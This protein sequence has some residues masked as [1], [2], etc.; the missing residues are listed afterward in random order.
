MNNARTSWFALFAPGILV[1]ATGVGAGDLMTAS[2][3]GSK[4]G[5]AILWAAAAGCL[6]KWTLNEGIA[7][8]QMATET[9]LLEGWVTRLGRWIQWVF[10][11][12]FLL[13]TFFVGGALINA[14]GVAGSNLL[15]LGDLNTSRIIWGTAHAVAGLGLVWAGGF[16]VFEKIMATFIALKFLAVIVTALLLVQDWGAVLQGLLVPRIPPGGLPWTLG[17]LG[18][19]GGT[20]TLLSYGYWIREKQ[21]SGVEGVRIC[22]VDLGVAYALTAMF[23]LAMIIIGSRIQIES[24]GARMAS[25]LA[26]QLALVLGPAGKWTFLIGFWGAVFS[27]LLGVWQSAPYLFA[28][29]LALRRGLSPEQYKNLDLSRTPAYR[30]YLVAISVVPLVLLWL[31]V[32]RI[33][34]AYAVMGAMFMP[35]LALTLL[36]MNNRERWVGG[37]FL[38][39]WFTNAVLVITLLLFAYM[40]VLQLI[41]QMPSTGG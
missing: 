39:G 38:S 37:R 11:A 29:F 2:M 34:L 22:R 8:W 33:Q 28:D 18:G 4:V 17:V 31:A 24:Q 21:R 32:E 30:I 20:V 7:R 12:Y 16:R 36:I 35:L 10:L 14:C 15:P 1:A 5:L 6:L 27:S 9:T 13:W 41:G 23:G 26:D 3:A 19:V 40:G 25:Q